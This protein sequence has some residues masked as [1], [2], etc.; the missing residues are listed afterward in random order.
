MT[1]DCAGDLKYSV[2]CIVYMYSYIVDYLQQGMLRPSRQPSSVG[3]STGPQYHTHYKRER[4]IERE[5]GGCC[6]EEVP[7]PIVCVRCGSPEWLLTS[8][9]EIAVGPGV[10][11]RYR[12]TLQR[13]KKS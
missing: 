7:W 9:A 3:S 2:W 13:E 10:I 8:E 4:A 12:G 6:G 5:R 1:T 11:D